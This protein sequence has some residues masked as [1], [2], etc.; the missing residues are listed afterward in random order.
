MENNGG[1]GLLWWTLEVDFLFERSEKS[2]R[3]AR[4][5]QTGCIHF[6]MQ[7]CRLIFY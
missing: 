3:E 7:A 6:L 2:I 5:T 1:E 4:I